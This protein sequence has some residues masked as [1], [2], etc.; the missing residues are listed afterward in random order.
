MC[1]SQTVKCRSL[2]IP[3]RQLIVRTPEIFLGHS[4]SSMCRCVNVCMHLCGHK[5]LFAF[6]THNPLQ[7]VVCKVSVSLSISFLYSPF[8]SKDFCLITRPS[9]GINIPYPPPTFMSGNTVTSNNLQ[10]ITPPSGLESLHRLKELSKHREPCLHRH[11]YITHH[12]ITRYREASFTPL[13]LLHLAILPPANHSLDLCHVQDKHI[14][15][16][17]QNTWEGKLHIFHPCTPLPRNSTAWYRL[18]QFL[19]Q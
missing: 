17:V 19:S 7:P 14:Q 6:S 5:S 8:A 15:E 11:T 12:C 3:K 2:S 16:K 10:P 18:W 9:P 13:S 4:V 1:F